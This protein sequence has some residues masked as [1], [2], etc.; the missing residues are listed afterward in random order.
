MLP[1]NKRK[2]YDI[3]SSEKLFNIEPELKEKIKEFSK[4]HK[5]SFYKV[6]MASVFTYL[7]RITRNS[8]VTAGVLTHNRS[9]KR[10]KEMTGNVC[11]YF[12]SL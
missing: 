3:K 1:Y 5:T 4:E 9:S 11:K 10:E 6:F 12:P 7:S 2:D 8:D